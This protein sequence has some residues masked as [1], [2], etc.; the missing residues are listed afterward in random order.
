[1]FRK[2]PVRIPGPNL[3]S[4]LF[5]LQDDKKKLGR[6]C[7]RNNLDLTSNICF[8]AFLGNRPVL[9]Q[10]HFNPRQPS[11]SERAD[12]ASTTY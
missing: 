10:K 9:V 1:M 6:G 3:G 11:P 7:C 8:V 5:D 2:D 4:D 12:F